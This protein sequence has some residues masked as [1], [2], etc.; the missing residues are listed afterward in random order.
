MSSCYEILIR[1]FTSQITAYNVPTSQMAVGAWMSLADSRSRIALHMNWKAQTL[2]ILLGGLPSKSQLPH[3]TKDTKRYHLLP[4]PSREE[5]ILISP[6]A[7]ILRGSYCTP[8]FLIHGTEDD[9]IPWQQTQKVYDA[10]VSKGIRAGSAVVEG[11][12]HLFDLYPDPD[13]KGWKAVQEGY[14]FLS[15]CL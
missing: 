12:E 6:Y 5:I 8:T 11:A 2:P 13:E 1:K 10:L 9:L 14:G 4:Q 15:S 7:Q 3:D